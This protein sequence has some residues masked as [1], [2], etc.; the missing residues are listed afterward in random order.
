MRETANG[1]TTNKCEQDVETDEDMFND[2]T[3]YN[4]L[5]AKVNVALVKDWLMG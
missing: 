5:R 4:T 2:K 3:I 1:K